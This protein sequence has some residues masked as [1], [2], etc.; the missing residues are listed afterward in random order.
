MHAWLW[1]GI[2]SVQEGGWRQQASQVRAKPSENVLA[3]LPGSLSKVIYHFVHFPSHLCT[4]GSNGSACILP[5]RAK[6]VPWLCSV[7]AVR[8][9]LLSPPALPGVA[10]DRKSGVGVH[11]QG[12]RWKHQQP[13]PMAESTS[14][15]GR[16]NTKPLFTGAEELCTACAAP[17]QPLLGSSSACWQ[18]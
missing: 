7:L 6:P 9:H 16:E 12:K 11:S 17:R 15:P 10:Q 13:T 5:S 8:S 14:L 4:A 18:L 3:A 2:S 1:L